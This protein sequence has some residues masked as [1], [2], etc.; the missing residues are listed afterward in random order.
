MAN[1]NN[2]AVIGI[3]QFGSSVCETL[4]EAHQDILA[5]D[6]SFYYIDPKA[7]DIKEAF[8]YIDKE[9]FY[10]DLNAFFEEHREYYESSMLKCF[11]DA[12]EIAD[13]NFPDDPTPNVRETFNGIQ[14]STERIVGY[15]DEE[16]VPA[17]PYQD[18]NERRPHKEAIHQVDRLQ[19]QINLKRN[20]VE[21]ICKQMN[22]TDRIPED[23]LNK[24]DEIDKI[25]F[26]DYMSQISGKGKY[27]KYKD[28]EKIIDAAET[29]PNGKTITHKRKN[30]MKDVLKGVASYKSISTY[31]SHVEDEEITYPCMASVRKHSIALSLLRELQS[32]GICP[33]NLSVRAEYKELENITTIFDEATNSEQ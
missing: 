8:K 6:K 23:F 29:F 9:T 27:Y 12:Y 21:R 17:N 10:P 30:R 33:L 18:K 22:F 3:G 14:Y 2:Y 11:E 26:F 16:P 7:Y 4:A 13:K 15:P 31:L 25:V 19:I 1:K 20:K 28:A 32:L 5:I 24:K